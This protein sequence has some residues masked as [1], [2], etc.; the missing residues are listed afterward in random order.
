MTFLILIAAF[1]APFSL[2]IVWGAGAHAQQNKPDCEEEL[3]P[4]SL[5][6]H[7]KRIAAAGRVRGLGRIRGLRPQVRALRR[8]LEELDALAAGGAESLLPGAQWLLDNGR[9]LEDA[10][11]ALLCELKGVRGLPLWRRRPRIMDFAREYLSHTGAHVD[12]SMLREAVTAWQEVSP[13]WLSELFTLPLALRA[14][15]ISRISSLATGCLAAQRQRLAAENAAHTLNNRALRHAPDDCTFWEHLLKC[16]R[17]QGNAEA[18]QMIDRRLD[19]LDQTAQRIVEAEHMRQTQERQAL[20]SAITS[21]R[22]MALIDWD[23][24]LESLSPVEML[25]REDPSG[26]YERMDAPTRALYRTQVSRF[27]KASIYSEGL[28][29]RCALECAQAHGTEGTDSL[30]QHVGFYLLDAGEYELWERLGSAPLRVRVRLFMHRRAGV[31]YPLAH[32][33]LSL[34]FFALFCLSRPSLWL[35]L[36]ALIVST[37]GAQEIIALWVRRNVPAKPLPCMEYETLPESLR[38]LVVIPTLLSSRQQALHMV[39]HLAVLQKANDD[40]QLSYLLL[41]DFRDSDAAQEIEDEDITKACMEGIRA[42]GPGETFLY[43][44]RARTWNDAQ[45]RFMGRER[46]RGA[47][48]TLNRLILTGES[49]DAFA[50]ASFDPAWLKGRFRQVITLDSDTIMPPGSALRLVGMITHPLMRPCVRD[51]HRR[52]CALIQPRMEQA[53]HRVTTPLCRVFGGPGGVDPYVSAVSDVYQDIAGR[54]SFAG[55]GIYD[56]ER[57]VEATEPFIQPGT[58]LSHDLLEGEL[59]RAAF[60]ENEVFYD[61]Q[62]ATLRAYF[63]RLHRWTRGDWQ[64]VGYLL[65]KIQ[66]PLGR[67]KNPLDL[68]S[69]FKIYDNLRRSL[70]PAAQGLLLLLGLLVSSGAA[71][72]YAL[73]LPSLG[74]LLSPS[75]EGLRTVLVQTALIAQQALVQAD[76]ALRS[77]YRLYVSHR[78]LLDW[79]TAHDAE[80]AKGKPERYA[81]SRICGGLLLLFGAA[82]VVYFWLAL[83]LG[84][85]WLCLPALSHWLDSP[86]HETLPL[87]VDEKEALLSYA[88]KTWAFFERIVTE[89]EHFLPIDNLQVVPER[90]KAHRT[91]PTNIGLYL[92]SCVAARYLGFLEPD[93]MAARMEK[94]VETLRQLPKWNGH[95]YNW[96]DTKTLAVLNPA[97]VSSVDSGNLAACLLCC[98]QALRA[99]FSRFDPSFRPL[100]Q[101]L[102]ALFDAMDLSAL[103]DAGCDLFYVGIQPDAPEGPKPTHYDLLASESRLLSFLSV[104][105]GQVPMR[106]WKSLG[107]SL[108]KTRK[109]VT[110]AS[111]SGTMFEY[112]MPALLMRLTPETLLHEACLQAVAEQI[113][114]CPRTPWGISES[115]HYQFDPALNYQYH[116]FGLPQLALRSE[117][118]RHVIAPYAAALALCVRPHAAAQNLMQ[119]D[120][121]GWLGELGFYE[122]ADYSVQQ[123]GGFAL[124]QS[125]MAHH[126]GMA[127]CAMCNALMDDVLVRLFSERLDVSAYSLLLEERVPQRRSLRFHRRAVRGEN[128]PAPR[129]SF[130]SR[131][132]S[133]GA[134][135][136]DAQVLYGEGTTLVCDARGG[137]MLKSGGYMLS[138]FRSDPF[139][140]GYGMRFYIRDADRV[141]QAGCVGPAG[142]IRFETG[143]AVYTQTTDGVETALTC[144]VGPLDGT[145]VHVLEVR[146][147]G[148]TARK[149]RVS[150]YMEVALCSQRADEAHPAFVKLFVETDI[151]AAGTLVASRRARNRDEET[152]ALFHTAVCSSPDAAF[153]EISDRGAFLGRENDALDRPAMMTGVPEKSAGAVVDPCVALLTDLPLDPGESCTLAYATGAQP[154]AG[155]AAARAA[156]YDGLEACLRAQA[157]ARI[158]AQVSA[159]Y[160]T[161]DPG[162]Q[163]IVQRAATY[164]L[165]N[166]QNP[167]QLA[168]AQKNTL[169]RE[170][171]WAL[172][173]SGDLPIVTV[174]ASGTADQAL[175]RMALKLHEAWRQWG[176]WADLVF[177]CP[178]KGDYGEPARDMLNGMIACGHAR[179]LIRKAGGVYVLEEGNISEPLR[180][181]LLSMSCLTFIGGR[182]TLGAQL[183][184]LRRMPETARPLAPAPKG[185]L[186]R[187]ELLCDNGFGGFD[188][189]GAYVID[190]QRPTPAPWCLLLSNPKM[191]CIATERGIDLTYASSSHDGRLTPFSNDPIVDR[192]GLRL[193]LIDEARGNKLSPLQDALRVIYTPGQARWECVYLDAIQTASLF[194]D[195]KRPV[196]YISLSLQNQTGRT[197]KLSV[198]LAADLILDTTVGQKTLIRARTQ[199]NALFLESPCMPGVAFVTVVGGKDVHISAPWLDG[200]LE[201]AGP[202]GILP[203][204]PA[205]QLSCAIKLAN[206]GGQTVAFCIGHAG[207][208]EEAA[209]LVSELSTPEIRARERQSLERWNERLSTLCLQTPDAVLNAVLGRWLPYQTIASRLYAKAGFYQ[210]GGATGFRDQLQDMLVLLY[211]QPQS[212]RAHLLLCAAHQFEDGDVQHWWH[213][214]ARGVRTHMTD[215]LLFLPFIAAAYVAATGDAAVLNERVV[216]LQNVEIP[217]GSEDYYGEAAP[218]QVEEPLLDH[219]LRAIRHVSFGAHGI[220]LI[221]TGDWNDAMNRVGIEGKGESVWL[222]WFFSYTARIFAPLCE[223]SVRDELL[224]L[225][226]DA[227]RAAD[228]EGWD[229]AWYRRAYMDDGTSLGSA[230]SDVCRI[231]CIAQCWAVIAGAPE[232]RANQAMDA[233]LSQL[234]DREHG[235]VRLLAPAFDDTSLEPGY[236]KGYLPGVRENGGQYTHGAAWAV[237]ALRKLGRTEE[238]WEIFRMLLPYT[239]ADTQEKAERYRVEPY[240]SAADIYASKQQ[241]GRGGWTWY[242]GS[243]AWIYVAGVYVLLGF[244]KRAERIRLSPTLPAD[245]DAFE[246]V[247]RYQS[248]A[249]TLRAERGATQAMLDGTPLSD[250]WVT[251]Y[252]D[253]REHIAVF[254]IVTGA[255]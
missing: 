37:A 32:G 117:T 186:P 84:L 26:V 83:P 199:K 149:L 246:I 196:Q 136:V 151:P 153:V 109:G 180:V 145:A 165:Y 53:A 182:E 194:V 126:Q 142:E 17:E 41:A 241:M 238:A 224:R 181:L 63:L 221:G 20:S 146:N 18:L 100:A 107:R 253:G 131:K 19:A 119:M 45:K 11:L 12:T 61:G 229:G 55:K 50:A 39:R 90:G 168:V 64:I 69:R 159:D 114:A 218:S 123:D 89:E 235:I 58:V 189:K 134:L 251:L 179:D 60:A 230:S 222:G 111:W 198:S 129:S 47:L 46:K 184:A 43:L 231:D 132:A 148:K 59:S 228:K 81:F 97:Y 183:K 94:T 144:C 71:L 173:I 31:L 2:L 209:A 166:G 197:A 128:R 170:E 206:D 207:T 115:G 250:G 125:H 220:P 76:A 245:W 78:G 6:A 25:L 156:Q 177:L 190:R 21:L 110:L 62:P 244:E 227:L 233:V 164:A 105:T 239:H 252:A 73:L 141:F 185:T 120:A 202:G 75:R 130:A 88:Q 210:A 51:G 104:A 102:E 187:T 226:D 163:N 243:A 9:L 30:S 1:A 23:P 103:Y 91:S 35:L 15:L 93:E 169:A 201:P 16:L 108:V 234:V 86:L 172:G 70:V 211:T 175:C 40:R 138:R 236:I 8:A 178:G 112:L 160:L 99:D 118:A 13:L 195:A 150:S 133:P 42:L 137:G 124:V 237:P 188:P 4:A 79:V 65:P 191:G 56:V 49:K 121:Q 85:S 247:Y 98:A 28:V 96:Y 54:G 223:P 155:A 205:A 193:T 200:S 249:Y 57:F 95:L 152:P 255:L 203:F 113:A 7:L 225:A 80:K 219:C 72:G 92:L 147:T 44:H 215:D 232:K 38:T 48:E 14:A 167:D 176:I 52:G 36:P 10:S 66:T 34:L 208:A 140:P 135:P 212:V 3:S 68:F 77:L 161:L 101:A 217:D 122:A 204:S 157:L 158:Q 116:A 5:C 87:C 33:L 24:L 192:S 248:S 22:T 242:T 127:L 254:P 214:P 162:A 82:N 171:I 216:Y 174:Q 139:A 74:L 27:A 213:P 143:C 29:A 67:Q 240:V 154:D 106:H